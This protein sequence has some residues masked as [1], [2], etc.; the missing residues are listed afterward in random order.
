M[1]DRLTDWL[2]TMRVKPVS[3][4]VADCMT[5]WLAGRWA[6]C[7]LNLSGVSLAPRHVD[8]ARDEL[9]ADP[10]WARR[11]LLHSVAVDTNSWRRGHD[12]YSDISRAIKST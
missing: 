4:G 10:T 2:A 6:L 7:M 12:G 11:T 3:V 5:D 1:A 8:C 9:N